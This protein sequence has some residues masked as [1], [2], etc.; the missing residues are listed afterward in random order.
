MPQEDHVLVRRGCL[1]WLLRMREDQVKIVDLRGVG[2]LCG[3]REVG[4]EG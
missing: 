3:F 4:S 2:K 1:S